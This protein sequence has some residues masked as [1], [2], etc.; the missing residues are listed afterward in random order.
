MSAWRGRTEHTPPLGPIANY[1]TYAETVKGSRATVAVEIGVWR[2][3]SAS[4]IAGAM[5]QQGR[6]GVLFAVDTWLGA[7]KK[8]TLKKHV[9]WA[10]A[11]EGSAIPTEA[12]TQ[13]YIGTAARPLP[14]A[15]ARH[16][17]D[18]AVP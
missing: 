18:A 10:K 13:R 9:A 7:L 11:G 5:K 15:W 4:H 2:G 8:P 6:G 14:L 17:V 1:E 16:P 12:L 3:L